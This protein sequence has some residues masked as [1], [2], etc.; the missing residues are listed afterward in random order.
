MEL[1]VSHRLSSLFFSSLRSPEWD[2]TL[3]W[4][5]IC[6]QEFSNITQKKIKENISPPDSA[7]V[8][9]PGAT[10]QSKC[11]KVPKAASIFEK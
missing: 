10:A 7:P 3:R 4:N 1:V 11:F 2:H 8:H 5:G 6:D 9:R